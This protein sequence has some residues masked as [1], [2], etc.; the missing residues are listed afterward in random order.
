MLQA[1]VVLRVVGVLVGMLVVTVAVQGVVAVT[2][3]V[4]VARYAQDTEYV[5]CR[6]GG[7]AEVNLYRNRAQPNAPVLRDKGGHCELAWAQR[8][9]DALDLRRVLQAVVVDRVVGVVV[10]MLVVTVAVVVVVAVA[11]VVV[12]AIHAQDAAWIV[13]RYAGH[14]AALLH[15]NCAHGSGTA[16][17]C[18]VSFSADEPRRVLCVSCRHG[19]DDDCHDD[20]NGDRHH[21]HANHNTHDTGDTHS[22]QHSEDGS[23]RAGCLRK[24]TMAT[25]VSEY[26]GIRL[27]AG[28]VKPNRRLA[29]FAADDARR[30]L[31]GYCHHDHDGDSHD[32]HNG[33]PHHGHANHDPHD[34]G[35]NHSLQQSEEVQG[36][37]AARC[38]RKLIVATFVLGL[39]G[40]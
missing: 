33:Y 25:C 12:V 9:V 30:V 17:T 40:H 21:E 4:V 19:H 39:Q 28:L 36:V 32:D 10:G 20:R 34:M 27:R 13:C 5:V 11:V 23:R 7:H 3:V 2:I 37:D 15:L 38:K 1:V 24:L 31:Y 16:Q 29:S 35:D 8:I 26:G 6:E 14:D 18:L 22:L